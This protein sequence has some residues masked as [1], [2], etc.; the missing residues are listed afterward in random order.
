MITNTSKRDAIIKF[1]RWGLTEGQE[2]LE[3]LFYARLPGA[4]ITKEEKAL[5]KIKSLEAGFRIFETETSI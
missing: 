3:A 1:I 2:Q 5:D 4:V